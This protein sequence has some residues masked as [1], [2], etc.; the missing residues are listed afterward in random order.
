MLLITAETLQSRPARW[1][2]AVNKGQY[3]SPREKILPARGKSQRADIRFY[4]P[5]PMQIAIGNGGTGL[6]KTR[7]FV[8][9]WNELSRLFCPSS[10]R[11]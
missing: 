10:S 3:L 4:A 2:S 1:L 11:L 8:P 9:S 6:I 5:R 7:P